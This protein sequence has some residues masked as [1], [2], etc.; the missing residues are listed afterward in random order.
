MARQSSLDVV[1]LYGASS[2]FLFK[3][4]IHSYNGLSNLTKVEDIKA[5][6]PCGSAVMDPSYVDEESCLIL[7]LARLVKDL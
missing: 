3:K 5:G 7:G 2:S 6:G 4:I 1:H